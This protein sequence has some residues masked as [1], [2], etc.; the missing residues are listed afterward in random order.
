LTDLYVRF[1][2]TKTV[3]I[4]IIPSLTRRCVVH[5]MG[6]DVSK[7]PATCILMVQNSRGRFLRNVGDYTPNHR[8]LTKIH[9]SLLKRSLR[10]QV[11][12]LWPT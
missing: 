2:V 3:S 12:R 8:P 5:T 6:K 7:V 1:R 4:N 9:C 11:T 10:P